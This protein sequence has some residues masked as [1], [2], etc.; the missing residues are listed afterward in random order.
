MTIIGKSAP[1]VLAAQAAVVL[2]HLAALSF[3][4]L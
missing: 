1:L 4:N 3:F 2:V